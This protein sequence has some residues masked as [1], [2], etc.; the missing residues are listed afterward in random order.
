MY[1][2]RAGEI[3]TKLKAF[4]RYLRPLGSDQTMSLYEIVAFP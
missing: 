4:E 1:G 3:R 2:P